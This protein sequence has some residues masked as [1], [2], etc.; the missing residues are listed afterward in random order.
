MYPFL[1]SCN[2]DFALARYNSDGSLDT[3]FG[4]GG[5]VTTGFGSNDAIAISVVIQPDGK[6][7]V[8]GSNTASPTGSDYALARYNS[9]GSLDT[10]FGIVA[11]LDGTAFFTEGGALAVLNARATVHDVDLDATGNYAG[12]SLTLARHGGADAQDKF[13]QRAATSR[14]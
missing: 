6:I 4:T 11:P 9:D 5:K 10:S 7:V 2:V 14:H 12:A 8:A 13:R 3:T 1:G